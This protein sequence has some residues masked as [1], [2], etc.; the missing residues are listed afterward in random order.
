MKIKEWKFKEWMAGVVIAFL[1]VLAFLTVTAARAKH[2]TPTVPTWVQL[3]A[4]CPTLDGALAV[5][6][7]QTEP[8][9]R[10]A[11]TLF[12]CFGT[13]N[14]RGVSTRLH[15][16]VGHAVWGADGLDDMM[17]L[18][19]V[20]DRA[21]SSMYSWVIKAVWEQLHPTLGVSPSRYRI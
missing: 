12:A 9:R 17:T 3:N 2:D 8:E 15:A 14:P 6:T 1:T 5:I 10:A 16:V 13:S 19:H 21:G 7:S 18:L 4:A 11:W 20:Y